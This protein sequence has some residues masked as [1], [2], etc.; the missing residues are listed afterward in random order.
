M[1][2]LRKLPILIL[3]VNVKRSALM[4]WFLPKQIFHWL[5]TFHTYILSEHI[6]WN[7]TERKGKRELEDS[8][9]QLVESILLTQVKG[10][11]FYT[12]ILLNRIAGCTS[13]EDGCT[14]SDG[15]VCSTFKE[16]ASNRVLL[17]DDNA[18]YLCLAEAAN[19]NM[20]PRLRQLFVNILIF[21]SPRTHVLK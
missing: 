6:V 10:E 19:C 13:F 1:L 18:H 4:G 9:L 20:L 3:L 5:D 17:E 21:N 7:K 16:A 14:L 11:K 15:A 8:V 12:K 2:P